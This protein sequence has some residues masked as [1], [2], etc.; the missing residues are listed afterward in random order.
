MRRLRE[1]NAEEVGAPTGRLR[2]AVSLS[3]M[4]NAAIDDAVRSEV[5]R[6][7]RHLESLA[8]EV[9]EASPVF[10][11]ATFHTANIT[12]WCGFLAAGILGVVQLN[13]RKPSRKTL[14]ATTLACYEYGASL[15]LIDVEMADA[16]AN[17]VC[18]SVAPFFNQTTCCS[19]PTTTGAALPL[20]FTNADDPAL[21]PKGRHAIICSGYAPFTALYNMTGQPRSAC[22]SASMRKACR[23]A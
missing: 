1:A 12:Y 20:G 11:E 2:V 21:V 14:E 8:H 22:R 23:S 7:A 4:F 10:D 19:T 9:T 3:G 13:G 16:L 18:R 17:V 6:V 15:K 5:M